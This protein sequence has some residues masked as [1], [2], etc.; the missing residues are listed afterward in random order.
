MS[1]TTRYLKGMRD[2]FDHFATWLPD[3]KLQ[4]G[5][6]GALK[7]GRF[8]LKTTLERLKIRFAPRPGAAGG[9]WE[10]SSGSDVSVDF[11][12]H[13]SMAVPGAPS[14]GATVR[15][16]HGGAFVFESIGCSTSVIENM[17]EV[18]NEVVLAWRSGEYEP[19]WVLI[20]R[21]V[22]ARSATILISDSDSAE[23]E[24]SASAPLGS[25]KSLADASLGVTAKR[26]RGEVTRFVAAAGITP[27]FGASRLHCRL[28]G[29]ATMET[30]RNDDPASNEATLEPVSEAS[31]LGDLVR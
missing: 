22:T 9:D 12:A 5:D 8:Y 28:L 1:T 27:L 24:L 20:D 14:G 26:W 10:H 6:I 29:G 7:N 4:L 19:S 3:E 31:W 21:L 2:K 13:A 18:G 25:M 30:Y 15:F 17:A 23:V 16:G 11:S